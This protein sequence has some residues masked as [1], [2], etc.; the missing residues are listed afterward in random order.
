MVKTR[1]EENNNP[2][3][4]LLI[5]LSLSLCISTSKTLS[6]R[7]RSI[8]AKIFFFINAIVPLHLT[9]TKVATFL[10]MT[11]GFGLKSVLMTFDRSRPRPRPRPSQVPP[12]QP[13]APLQQGSQ[14]REFGTPS[15]SYKHRSQSNSW[16]AGV[17]VHEPQQAHD[18]VSCDVGEKDSLVG[19]LYCQSRTLLRWNAATKSIVQ[20]PKHCYDML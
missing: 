20:V 8:L 11:S 19:T 4:R 2:G 3:R 18:A 1:K 9:S 6:R 16:P 7:V 5:S 13:R 17:V 15:L 12:R 14:T 10:N